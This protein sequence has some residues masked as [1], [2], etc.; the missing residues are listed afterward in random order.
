MNAA[1]FRGAAAGGGLPAEI[2]IKDGAIFYA[3]RRSGDLDDLTV[4]D[5][6]VDDRIGDDRVSEHFSPFGKG[7]VCCDA[8]I[9]PYFV[10]G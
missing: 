4:M 8:L 2:L 3:V 6:P 7:L 9:K 1:A 10:T 5:Q